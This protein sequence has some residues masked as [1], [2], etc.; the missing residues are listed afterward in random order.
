[1]PGL[2][3]MFHFRELNLIKNPQENKKENL[4]SC[5]GNYQNTR[6]KK[7]LHAKNILLLQQEDTERQ[8]S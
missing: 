2:F 4:E 6:M 5:G 8:L 1:M 3:P 7:A